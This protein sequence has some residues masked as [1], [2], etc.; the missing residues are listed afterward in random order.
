MNARSAP[1]QHL[2]FE[3][4]AADL[5]ALLRDLQHIDTRA[6]DAITTELV[7]ARRADVQVSYD[8]LRRRLAEWLFEHE[9]EMRPEQAD[10]L[11]NE[12]GRLFS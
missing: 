7:A 11:R 6:L 3:P 1:A 4:R 10:L 5:L 8:E 12:W 2:L 9:S